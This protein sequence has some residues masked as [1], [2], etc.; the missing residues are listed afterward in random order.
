M[1]L[2]TATLLIILGTSQAMALTVDQVEC[3]DG[4]G[5]SLVLHRDVDDTL[6]GV[7]ADNGNTAQIECEKGGWGRRTFQA[8]IV[9]TGPWAIA[10][11]AYGKVLK[12]NVVIRMELSQESPLSAKADYKSN[13]LMISGS[14]PQPRLLECKT[15]LDR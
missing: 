14:G 11:G 6:R 15:A 7:L 1:K 5:N 9:C 2:M 13:W 8:P 10:I 4:N 3:S 12:R